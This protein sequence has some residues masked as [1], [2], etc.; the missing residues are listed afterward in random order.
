MMLLGAGRAATFP[1]LVPDFRDG[2]RL[3][4]RS[5]WCRASPQLIGMVIVLVGFRFTLR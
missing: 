2:H 4:R 5:A 3:S 1:A